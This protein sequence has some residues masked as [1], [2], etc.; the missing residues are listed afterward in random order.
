M[1]WVGL[2]MRACVPSLICRSTS[3]TNNLRTNVI[4]VNL[5][6]VEKESSINTLHCITLRYIALQYIHV[7]K[8]SLFNMRFSVP[9]NN[10][11]FKGFI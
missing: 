5:F 6:K 9:H 2:S 10:N 1:V 8:I 11:F 3:Y 7:N 4:D